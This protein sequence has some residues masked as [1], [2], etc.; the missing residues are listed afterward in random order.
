MKVLLHDCCAPCGAQVIQELQ[1]DGHEVS[2]YFFNPNI[3]P[4]EE[5]LVRFEEMKK[6]C[7]KNKVQLIVN[8]YDHDEW[9]DRVKGHETD[10]EGG[11]RC[12]LCFMYRLSEVAQK[13]MEEG[14]ES[15]ATTLTI[16]PHKNAEIINQIGHEL[17]DF[18]NLRFIDTVWRK[19]EGFKKSCKISEEEGFH[20]QDYCGCEYSIRD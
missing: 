5:Y 19:N 16:S 7:K 2:V 4:E 8:Q 11:E 6:Y 15:F 13:A 14:F 9:L 1:K 17:A 3:Y 20:R 10:K 18:Y 12:K